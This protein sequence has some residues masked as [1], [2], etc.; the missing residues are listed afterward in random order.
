M[1]QFISKSIV[2]AWVFWLG[3]AAFCMDLVPPQCPAGKQALWYCPHER[4]DAKTYGGFSR[5]LFNDL[6]VQLA[7]IGYCLRYYSPGDSL[8]SSPGARDNLCLQIHMNDVAANRGSDYG[9]VEKTLVVEL[10]KI[11]E[12]TKAKTNRLMLTLVYDSDDPVSLRS[13]FVKKIVENLRTQYICNVTITSDPPGVRVKTSGQLTDLTPL[14]WVVPVGSLQVQCSKMKY[15]AFNKELM[16]S[17]P[18]AYSYFLQMRKRQFYNSKY[19]YP[20]LALLIS[21]AVFYYYD[22]YY[23]DRYNRLGEYEL[24]NSPDSFRSSFQN[25]R[26]FENASLASFASGC[27]LLGLTFWF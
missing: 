16:L 27:C 5:E 22:G 15:L 14:E 26:N 3:P 23:Y 1:K 6:A 25:A 19:F 17:K 12:L 13:V 18:G 4:L 7:G 20:A 21:S 11:S 8:A 9:T 10:C 24:R 2:T